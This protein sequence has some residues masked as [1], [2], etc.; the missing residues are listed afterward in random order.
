MNNFTFGPFGNSFGIGPFLFP[1]SPGSDYIF[2]I[3]ENAIYWGRDGNDTLFSFDPGANNL[4][5]VDLL[6][7]DLVDATLFPEMGGTPRNWQNRFILGDWQQPYYVSGLPFIFGLNQF[8]VI[9]DFSSSQDTIQLHGTPEDYQLVT[10]PVGTALLWRQFPALDLIAFLPLVSDLNLEDSYFQ[11][12]GDR[13]PEGPVLEKIQ[14]LG[15]EGIDGFTSLTTDS[16][17]NIYVTGGTQGNIWIVKYDSDGNQLWI[18]D[19]GTSSYDTGTDLVSDREGNLYLVGVTNGDLGGANAGSFDVWLAKYD[20]DGNQLWI[21]QFGNELVDLSYSIDVDGEGNVY[22]SGHSAR[23]D[24]EGEQALLGQSLYPWVAKYDSDGNQL[25]FQEF[26]ISGL[27]EAYGVNVDSNDRVYATGW[28]LVD[29]GGENAGLYDIWL[30]QLDSD[31]NPVWIEQFGSEDYDFPWGIDTD[32]QGNIYTTGWTLGDLGG[33]NAGSYDPW[34]AKYDSEGNQQW[35]RQFGTSGDDGTGTFLKAIEVDSNDNIFLTG[36]TDSNLG[37]ANAGFYDPWVAK[38]DSDGNQLWIQQFGTPEFDYAGSISS[39][40]ADNLYVTG[41]TEG[42]LGDLNAG[43]VDGWI[44][45]LDAESGI[46]QDFS[47]TVDIPIL[48]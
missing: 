37:G 24:S 32:S 7:G 10:T 20:S 42:S 40:N 27:T 17:R 25:W 31:G 26:E 48:G 47:G 29:F 4:L 21:Q 2:S 14:Q 5:Q 35:I 45:K 18:Q 39:D 16:F 23:A 28:T 38:Y 19:F 34:V 44:A 9:A 22:L 11:F 1:A 41:W 6:I 43:A 36:Y 15:T 30:A 46:L 8:A 33:A 13:P 3:Q 12:Q